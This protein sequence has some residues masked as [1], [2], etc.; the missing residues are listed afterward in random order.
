M[1]TGAGQ[2]NT[3]RNMCCEC[4]T[5]CVGILSLPKTPAGDPVVVPKEIE[6]RKGAERGSFKS[7]LEER[8]FRSHKKYD[9]FTDQPTEGETDHLERPIA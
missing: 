9:G 4:T 1:T 5:V 7:L 6:G 2:H 8:L 3:W